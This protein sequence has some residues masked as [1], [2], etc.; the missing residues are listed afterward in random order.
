MPLRP[1]RNLLRLQAV[2]DEFQAMTFWPLTTLLCWINTKTQSAWVL[3]WSYLR[4]NPPQPLGSDDKSWSVKLKAGDGFQKIRTRNRDFHDVI[5]WR[6]RKKLFRIFSTDRFCI[7]LASVLIGLALNL[8]KS[9]PASLIGRFE[10]SAT[11]F[12]TILY[13][14]ANETEKSQN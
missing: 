10:N 5:W 7:K 12:I 6:L 2:F 9:A 1:Y 13:S 11:Y 4:T 3:T 14:S 8:H